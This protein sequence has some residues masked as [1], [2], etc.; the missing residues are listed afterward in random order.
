MLV[1][2]VTRVDADTS[3]SGGAFDDEQ[4]LRL[5]GDEAQG[6][7]RVLAETAGMTLEQELEDWRLETEALRRAQAE[8]PGQ[9]PHQPGAP[10]HP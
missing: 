4:G 2:M 6:A 8:R 5:R 7:E 10:P 3:I 1:R 9:T